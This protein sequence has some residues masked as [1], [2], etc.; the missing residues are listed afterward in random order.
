MKKVAVVSIQGVPAQYGGFESL[1][2]NLIGEY[3]SPDVEYTVFCSSKDMPQKLETYKG[4]KLK[5]IPLH[6]N[7]IQS[8]FYDMIALIC[9]MRKY[10]VILNL[11]NSAP[12]F[13]IYK[14]LCKGKLIINI[15]GLSQFR[16]K[17]NK[18]TQKYI[19]LL[20]H[21][22]TH[23]ADIIVSDNKAI[24][25]YVLEEYKKTSALI[26]YGGDHVLR[27]ISIKC[28][29]ETLRNYNLQKD[30]YAVA[31]CRIEPENN[32]HLVLE[33]F[34]D[35]N[36]QLVYI[37]NWNRSEYGRALRQKYSNY[38]NIKIL[39]PIY[40]LDILYT[41]RYNAKLYV[42]GHKVGGTNPSLVEAMF[43]G[44]PIACY[45][46]TYNRETTNHKALYFSDVE[47][48]KSILEETSLSGGVELLKYAQQHYTWKHII[49]QYEALYY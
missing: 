47:E 8:I 29:A 19:A 41:L 30:G 11:G 38:A 40:D 10:D 32:C 15:D 13:W 21:N 28:Q 6:A 24:Q 5:Y 7:G 49:K 43:F 4:A 37:G 42:H 48:L 20:K 36:V 9:S 16:D 17:Y 45:D 3:K 35:S 26:A 31:V 27:D 34:A 23:Y 18:F 2:E 44:K 46:V 1:V 12:I 14:K 39:D 22:E 25:D 33:A